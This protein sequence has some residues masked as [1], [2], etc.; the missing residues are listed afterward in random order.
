[1]SKVD[2][3]HLGYEV[4]SG[5]AVAIPL[6]HTFVTG[7][8][9]LSGKTTTLRAIVERSG[10]RALA[11]VTKRGENF[12]GR[13]ISPYLPREGEA[14]IHWRLVETILASALG[15]R[16]LK[17]ERLWIINAA[18]GAKSLQHVRDN[19]DR[20]LAATKSG[21]S[22]EAY[23]LIRE[24]LDLVLPDMRL[25]DA[26][27]VLELEPGLN[28]M[29]LTGV[30]L[31][32]QALVIRASLE[33]INAHEQGVLTVFPE[34]WEFAPRGRSAPAK[35]EAIAMI[36]KGAVLHNFL[37]CDSQDLAGVDTVVRQG[38]S[39][40]ILGVQRELNELK[41]TIQMIPA[42]IKRP[43]PEDVAQLELGQFY[44]CWG[45]HA[46]KTY[47][48]PTWMPENL[49][50]QV[51]VGE[52]DVRNAAAIATAG[53]VRKAADAVFG[54]PM[55]HV[56]AIA[57]SLTSRPK[58]E[59]AVTKTEAETLTRE[60]EQLKAENVDLRRRL[61]VLEKD[62]HAG[63][64]KHV[65]RG[66]TKPAAAA[67]A[68]SVSD[69]E[70]PPAADSRATAYGAAAAASTTNGNIDDATYQA[71][72]ARLIADAPAILQVTLEKPRLEVTI[73][74]P[75]LSF[76]AHTLK[77]R[78]VRLLSEGFFAVERKS[79]S[80]IRAALKRTGPD[81]NTANIGRAMDEFVKA[82]VFVDEGTGYLAVP[83]IEVVARE[84]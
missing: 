71:I 33:R 19:V 73:T 50:R 52:L 36:R 10:Q 57:R 3:I 62:Q 4:G 6:A 40:W 84:Q 17:W 13:R 20:L 35:D 23:T 51:A 77:W 32:L 38:A 68:A 1:M 72:K 8:T 41:R 28:V 75:T 11:F 37:L 39:V 79:P 48:R 21:K 5:V 12:E 56:G 31:Q 27:D 83:G 18:K 59:D 9:Q 66:R 45:T 46:I 69:H 82:G 70:R 26:S 30:G 16:K 14:P 43:K 15:E 7:Q 67:R 81:A 29:D 22:V 25:L 60:N 65:D 54:R 55:T 76:D 53:N 58:E 49:A 24:Y 34:A 74:R 61:E 44:A 80:Q 2:T 64:A 47:V 78:I 42:G 63:D